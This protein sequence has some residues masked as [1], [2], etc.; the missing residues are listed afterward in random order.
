MTHA[1]A[2]SLPNFRSAME[3][4]DS[5]GDGTLTPEAKKQLI[6]DYNTKKGPVYDCIKARYK[7]GGSGPLTEYNIARIEEDLSNHHL[8]GRYTAFIGRAALCVRYL[9]YTSDFGEAFRPLANPW[10]VRGAYGVSWG[11]VIADVAYKGHTLRTVHKADNYDLFMGCTQR[12][13]F[14]S[15]ASMI[16][17]AIT[18]H[19]T[20][21]WS[22]K[23][24]LSR[25]GLKRYAVWGPTLCGLGVVPFLPF[26]FD[27]PVEYVV[28]NAFKQ[29][30]T[31][32]YSVEHD[33]H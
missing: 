33:H 24:I 8:A 19:E 32:K 4:Y 29:I 17:P 13:L 31:P 6:A 1:V 20:V 14:Q 9:A 10:V 26:M 21:R 16:F 2:G 23:F 18:I 25:P 28:E 5:R 30:W 15:M 7:D 11:Y 12:A 27:E 3:A 22:K